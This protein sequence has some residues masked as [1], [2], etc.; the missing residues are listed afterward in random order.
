MLLAGVSTKVL[1]VRVLVNSQEDLNMKNE[2]DVP[3]GV[4]R[5]RDFEEG[6]GIKV[7]KCLV[8]KQRCTKL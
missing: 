3:A 2:Y 6:L 7:L 4:I 8:Y 5:F 1:D